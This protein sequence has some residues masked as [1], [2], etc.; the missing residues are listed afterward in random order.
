MDSVRE[1]KREVVKLSYKIDWA[2]RAA[3]IFHG[4]RV[5]LNTHSTRILADVLYGYIRTELVD[6]RN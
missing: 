1:R 4:C 6:W 5:E 3:L 2:I